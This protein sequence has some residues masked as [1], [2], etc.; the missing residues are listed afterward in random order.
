M[1]LVA[2]QKNSIFYSS[3]LS[4]IIESDKVLELW[5][6]DLNLFYFHALLFSFSFYFI[7]G[8]IF[9]FIILDLDKEV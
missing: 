1:V 7:L 4:M 3:S 9:I 5:I 8:F 2:N 6:M